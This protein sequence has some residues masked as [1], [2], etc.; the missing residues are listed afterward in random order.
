MAAEA[1]NHVL[2][3][4]PT[5]PEVRQR[6]AA[7]TSALDIHASSVA[8][9]KCERAL[10]M[11]AFKQL[12]DGTLSLDADGRIA[13]APWRTWLGQVY[14]NQDELLYMDVLNR[15]VKAVG[16]VFRADDRAETLNRC[17]RVLLAVEGRDQVA[18]ENLLRDSQGR[19]LVVRRTEAGWLVYGLGENGIDDGGQTHASFGELLDI[20]L[21]P[22]G[23]PVSLE[24]DDEP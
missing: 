4:A 10:G 7:A 19:E 16:H 15:Y 6:L 14:L 3:V 9:V 24:S 18:P 21:G 17:L 20:G 8:A 2:R 22:L 12:R 11:Q 1:A 5:S 23:D 13:N